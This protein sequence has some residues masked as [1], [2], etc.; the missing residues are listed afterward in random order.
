MEEFSKPKIMYSEITAFFPFVYDEDGLLC[1]NKIFFITAKDESVSLKFLTAIF[2][3][4]LCKLW[5]WYNCP[6]L[7]GG[8]REI[9]KVY[10]ENFCIPSCSNQQP[11]ID[12]A[13]RMLSL[14]RDLQTKRARFLK[15]LQDNIP[16]V[17]V[18]GALETFDSLDFAGFV[19]E[20]KKQKIKLSLSQQDEWDEYFTIY[21]DAL[22]D[23]SA[24][25][26]E[27]DRDIDSLV[28]ALYGL[29]DD[30]RKVIEG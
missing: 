16:E 12:L 4:K 15:R 18:T 30:E 17:K 29:T 22:N 3:S 20:L 28:Y 27:T 25:I 13:D 23:I 5:I 8:T 26:A 11:F 2:N 10:F 14:N 9:R 24:Q 19:A 21:K 6:E 7:L 1:N